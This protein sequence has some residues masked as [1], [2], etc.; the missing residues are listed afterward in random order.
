MTVEVISA[1]YDVL[2]KEGAESSNPLDT[3]SV[4]RAV[5]DGDLDR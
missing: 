4:A 3:D 2:G 5:S 1:A